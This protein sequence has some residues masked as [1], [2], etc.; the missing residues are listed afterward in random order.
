MLHV[1][2]NFFRFNILIYMGALCIEIKFCKKNTFHLLYF[3]CK[4]KYMAVFEHLQ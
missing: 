4:Y 3:T 2:I 1:A